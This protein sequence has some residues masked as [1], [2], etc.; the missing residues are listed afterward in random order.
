MQDPTVQDTHG[1]LRSGRHRAPGADVDDGMVDVIRSEERLLVGTVRRPVERVTVHRDVVVE[2]VTQTFEVR[3]EVLRVERHA[4]EGDS[5][6]APAGQA[7][8]APQ[9]VEMVLREE[10]PVVTLQVVPVER[11]RI[12]VVSEQRV[13][14]VG[15]DVRVER[16]EVDALGSAAPPQ[17]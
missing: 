2:Q 4:L 15:D 12:G 13:V 3:R 7:L 11:V 16:V 14:E 17:H 9:V 10:R 1:P 5:A 8:Q 6:S